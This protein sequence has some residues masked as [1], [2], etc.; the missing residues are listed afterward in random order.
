MA[1]HKQW[2]FFGGRVS[3]N[4]KLKPCCWKPPSSGFESRNF[5]S[6][7]LRFFFKGFFPVASYSLSQWLNFKLS[8]ITCL[9]GKIQ[10]KL[11][12]QGP[13]RLSESNISQ[14]LCSLQRR[15]C[16]STKKCLVVRGYATE[17]TCELHH[18]LVTS[19]LG[20]KKRHISSVFGS[21]H[22][23]F[24]P[25][26]NNSLETLKNQVIQSDLFIPWLEVT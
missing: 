11:L 25:Q 6:P 16:F 8:G 5:Q 20:D 17:M 9:V 18:L 24:H 15:L 10:F 3:T 4:W 22:L 7:A 23:S 12:S 1:L 2:I 21:T 19:V 26:I 14:Y 13:G